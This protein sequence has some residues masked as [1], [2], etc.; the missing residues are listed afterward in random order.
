MKVTK[1]ITSVLCFSTLISIFATSS[2]FATGATVT[3]AALPS[4][5]A[6]AVPTLSGTM[7]VILSLLLFAVAFRVAKQKNSN[8]G[9]L[10]ITLIGITA[11]TMGGSG[12]KLISEVNAG[13]N[14]TIPL[15]PSSTTSYRIE[16]GTS[17]ELRNNT[18]QD[19]TIL[20][21]V[22]DAD[23]VCFFPTGTSLELCAKPI[24]LSAP[25]VIP[26]TQFCTI[27][28]QLSKENIESR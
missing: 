8:A 7:L 16:P 25:I 28:C 20:S 3:I 1:Y 17:T 14:T 22:P 11:I 6:T 12:I 2:A 19:V 13:V 27:Y 4:N 24:P 10:F 21:I 15:D 18:G 9:K 5:G 26:T 23:S